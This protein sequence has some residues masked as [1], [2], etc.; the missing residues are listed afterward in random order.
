MEM[1]KVR[2]Q[3]SDSSQQIEEDWRRH[4]SDTYVMS[5]NFLSTI[6]REKQKNQLT[7]LPREVEKRGLCM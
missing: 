1:L 3:E 6:F 2:E 5:N 4:R 7:I